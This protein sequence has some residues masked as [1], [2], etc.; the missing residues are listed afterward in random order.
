M[1]QQ[2]QSFSSTIDNSCTMV[3]VFIHDSNARVPC[4]FPIVIFAVSFSVRS[5]ILP[6]GRL[7]ILLLALR[8]LLLLDDI[9]FFNV[10]RSKF[11]LKRVMVTKCRFRG[12][13]KKGIS[14]N[15]IQFSALSSVEPFWFL[16]R[17]FWLDIPIK[18]FLRLNLSRCLP[19]QVCLLLPV[20]PELNSNSEWVARCSK[21]RP[22]ILALGGFLRKVYFLSLIGH[23]SPVRNFFDMLFRIL[24]DNQLR[25]LVA[26]KYKAPIKEF[27]QG[28]F[29]GS[30]RGRRRRCRGCKIFV[31]PSSI[32]FSRSREWRV[33]SDR[34]ELRICLALMPICT[35]GAL[36]LHA[37]QWVKQ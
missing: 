3:V 23:S 5:K 29:F 1:L 8:F 20:F 25:I 32:S 16:S 2:T 13:A 9:S 26:T 4:F 35:A 33:A 28:N 19:F 34:R 12:E 27:G 37:F 31:F 18:A 10:L 15:W 36:S 7:W 11:Y 14:K 30:S 17:S 6:C 21:H 22:S 24:G